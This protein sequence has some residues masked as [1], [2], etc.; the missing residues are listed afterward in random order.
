MVVALLE[1]AEMLL[2]EA[3]LGLEFG[4]LGVN[5]SLALTAVQ[6][7]IAYLEGNKLRAAEDLSTAAEEIYARLDR[8]TTGRL[9]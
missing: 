5:T 6:G 4:R 1:Q 7:L 3:T 2:K 9:R 8:D